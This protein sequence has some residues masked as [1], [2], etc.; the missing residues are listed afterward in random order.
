[1]DLLTSI[2]EI[3]ALKEVPDSQLEWLIKEGEILD[4]EPESHLFKPGDPIDRL[5]VILEGS[6]V[7]KVQQGNQFRVVGTFDKQTISGLLPYSRA[8]VAQG[9]AQV[10]KPAKVLALGKAKFRAM[11]TSQEELTTALVHVMSSRIREFTKNQQQ[12]DKMMALGKLSAGL[13]HEL[14]NPSAAIV[15][16]A[17]TLSG[18]LKLVPD[19][20]KKVIKIR[21][22]DAQVDAVNDMLFSKMQ[23][24]I[25][26][27]SMMERSE[28]EDDLIDW[29]DDHD[30]ENSESVAENLV[31]FGFEDDDLEEMKTGVSDD[32][33]SAVIN[34]VD[35]MLTTERLVGEIEEAS[36][37]IN[38]LVSS[39]KSYTHMDQAPEKVATDIR[40][41]LE[42]T[43]TM[44]NHKLNK[45]GIKV[46]R[47]FQEDLPEP[48]ILVSEI[49]QVWT[50]LIDNA[51]DAME[52]SE[53]R[54]LLVKTYLDG[55][56]INIIIGDTG[57]GIP[58]GIQDKVFDPFF[59]TKEIGKGTGLGMEVVHRIIKNQHNGA[60]TF[61][62][63]PGKTQFKVCFP[64]NQHSTNQ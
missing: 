38:K 54:E 61:E 22:S 21:M 41:G 15:R 19:N 40:T 63:E 20:F 57:S 53:K 50:N 51:I 56:F 64:I 29:L 7:L 59:T 14:N 26:T 45:S 8:Q 62:T 47:D 48:E 46:I 39:V 16:S 43:L 27:L 17:Q 9:F 60:V 12:N 30:I 32:D 31:E 58:K 11:I 52:S 49:N 33:L 36:Q 55:R 23:N 25:Q 1:M 34:W 37:R 35:Q 24:G 4:F 28:M 10:T 13:A 5:F 2:K 3:E 42:S 6:M 18:H 44:L